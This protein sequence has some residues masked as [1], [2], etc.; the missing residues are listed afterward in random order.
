MFYCVLFSKHIYLDGARV[1]C[2]CG[3]HVFEQRLLDIIFLP[4]QHIRLVPLWIVIALAMMLS[5]DVICYPYEKPTRSALMAL[6]F[7]ALFSRAV[8]FMAYSGYVFFHSP[9]KLQF[10]LKISNCQLI[11]S[12]VAARIIT[13]RLNYFDVIS[14]RYVTAECFI[15]IY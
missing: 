1:C 9:Q 14:I 11:D 12:V 4:F 8:S 7:R 5:L 13:T 2:V 10:Y 6:F 15:G 3:I